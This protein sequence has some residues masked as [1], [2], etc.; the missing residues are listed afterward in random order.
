MS[1]ILLFFFTL[2]V[3]IRDHNS[4]TA[5]AFSLPVQRP[6]QKSEQM[7]QRKGDPYVIILCGLPGSGKSSFANQLCHRSP[8]KFEYINQD[9]LKT[10][11]KCL[12]RLRSA[13]SRK[14]IPIVDRC[15]FDVS[16]RDHF[17][18]TS[19]YEEHF[20]ENSGRQINVQGVDI[21]TFH[22]PRHANNNTERQHVDA[23]IQRCQARSNH[24]TINAQ[25]AKS[26]VQRIYSQFEMPTRNEREWRNMFHLNVLN[27]T[28]R[29]EILTFYTHK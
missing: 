13:L 18:N 14:K 8:N 6:K 26:V 25:N 10:R 15:N 12:T 24:E 17:Y 21:I 9:K 4:L 7:P 5:L 22:P 3:H 2:F 1:R 27:A 29:N 11:K 20:C 23:C 16:Q 28:R 19:M